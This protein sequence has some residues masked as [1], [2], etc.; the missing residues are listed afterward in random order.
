MV[1]VDVCT[2]MVSPPSIV[3]GKLAAERE[4]SGEKTDPGLHRDAATGRW[5]LAQWSNPRS[6]M[7]AM[8][9]APSKTD[10]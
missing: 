9:L 8:S 3:E 7:V 5:L 10:T 4:L 1:R 2:V 6:A